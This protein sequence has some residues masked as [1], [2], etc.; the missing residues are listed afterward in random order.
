MQ[1]KWQCFLEAV[2]I[3]SLAP[4]MEVLESK[5]LPAGGHVVLTSII[6]SGMGI[7]FLQGPIL[8]LKLWA[9]GMFFLRV[10]PDLLP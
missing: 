6:T 4:G 9:V 2:Q 7:L 3:T 10:S 1:E 8:V 5:M